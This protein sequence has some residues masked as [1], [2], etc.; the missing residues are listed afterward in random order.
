V[1]FPKFLQK[2]PGI[3]N[4]LQKYGYGTV[5]VFCQRNKDYGLEL[6]DYGVGSKIKFERTK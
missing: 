1:D 2:Y 4:S 6:V 3:M 5:Q